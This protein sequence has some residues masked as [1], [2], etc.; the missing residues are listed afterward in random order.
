MFLGLRYNRRFRGDFNNPESYGKE[1]YLVTNVYPGIVIIAP[2][3]CGCITE[4]P[5]PF[6]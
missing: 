4:Q 1:G 6:M 5:V 3:G 2:V